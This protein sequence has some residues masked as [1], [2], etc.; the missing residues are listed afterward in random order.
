MDEMGK[1]NRSSFEG[2]C[3]MKSKNW[4]GSFIVLLTLFTCLRA[5]ADTTIVAF[6]DSTT[7]SRGT[8]KIYADILRAELPGHGVKAEVINAGVGGHNTDHAMARFEKDVIANNPDI[9]IIQFGINDAAVDVWKRPPATKSRVSVEAYEKNLQHFIKV[10][11]K[12]KVKIILMTPNPLRW[13]KKMLE[14]YGE[15]PYLPGDEGGFNV[16]LK[17][18]AAKLR[19]LAKS[20]DTPLIDIYGVFEEFGK[21]EGQSVD[22]LLLDGIHPNDK[23]QR[24]V[25]DHLIEMITRSKALPT[26]SPVATK[27]LRTHSGQWE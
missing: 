12:K 9:V 19:E 15:A 27:G 1:R 10:L 6:G 13:N 26:P 11:K 7:A 16:K 21:G 23:G 4:I 20:S 17:G 14:L 5:A 22:D 2:Q 8:L 24:I 25:A 18:Y 3:D